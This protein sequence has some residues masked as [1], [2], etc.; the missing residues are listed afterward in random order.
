MYATQLD[1][2]TAFLEVIVMLFIPLF[3]YEEC[4]ELNKVRLLNNVT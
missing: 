4:S 3:L 1:G 2:F